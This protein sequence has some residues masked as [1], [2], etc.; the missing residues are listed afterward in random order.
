MSKS[1]TKTS[2]KQTKKRSSPAH[3][4]SKLSFDSTLALRKL[5]SQDPILAKLIKR[6]GPFKLKL[7][8]INSPFHALTESIVYQQ[9]HGKAAATIFARVQALF[10]SPKFLCPHEVSAM[11]EESLRSAGLSQS[12]LSSIKDL[13]AKAIEGIVPTAA[14]LK[15]MDDQEIIERLTAIR[16]IG[17]WTVE[18]LLIFRL[19]RPDVL[20]VHDYGVRKGFATIYGYDHLPKPKELE[21][22]GERWRPYRTVAAWYLWRALDV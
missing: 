7:G 21:A 1:L 13:A 14:Q 6:I 8:P 15:K 10:A 3:G 22:Y 18:M 17:S 16:G 9:L 11:S 12:K 19:G 2:L 5:S 20:P 4:N